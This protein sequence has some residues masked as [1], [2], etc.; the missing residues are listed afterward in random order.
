MKVN[1]FLI[2]VLQKIAMSP[3]LDPIVGYILDY[4]FK[5]QVNMADSLDSPS[6]YL[7]AYS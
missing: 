3:G 6:T 4:L 5:N 2:I 1:L 7:W